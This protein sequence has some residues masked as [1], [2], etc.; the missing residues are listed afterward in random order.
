MKAS[1]L[2][3]KSFLEFDRHQLGRLSNPSNAKHPNYRL[4]RST[5]L[6]LDRDDDD[7]ALDGY[8]DDWD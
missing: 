7:D 6:R 5:N 8:D 4:D 3:Q 1:Q 2:V